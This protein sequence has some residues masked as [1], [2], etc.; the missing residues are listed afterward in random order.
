MTENTYR[1]KALSYL[2][3]DFQGRCAYCLK[4]MDRLHQNQVHVD[5]F[6]CHKRNRKRNQYKNLMLCC[7]GC[8]LNK[9]FKHAVNPY[10]SKQRLLNCTEENE[11]PEH[12][13]EHESG[14]WLG[15]TDEGQYHI[16]SIELNEPALI[17]LR[18]ERAVLA[19][20]LDSV[21]SEERRV[22]KG[23]RSERRRD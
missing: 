2:R 6:D 21:R 17:K 22:G 14:V 19:K 12:I 13:E 18:E 8:N 1:R 10:N 16:D 20:R 3:T 11:F 7:G 15:K 23:G 4:A 5:H 9:H